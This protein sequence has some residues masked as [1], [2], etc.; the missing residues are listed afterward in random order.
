[1]HGLGRE[2]AEFIIAERDR[3]GPYRSPVDFVRRV[4]PDRDALEQLVF[5]GALDTL[6]AR[7]GRQANRR[8]ILW[9]L[10]EWVAAAGAHESAQ[11]GLFAS[12]ELDAGFNRAIATGLEDFD[13]WP[14]AIYEYRA[15]NGITVERHIMAYLRRSLARQGVKRSDQL[16]SLK[17]GSTVTVAGLCLR[18]HRPPTRSGRTVV[19]ACLEDEAGL[20]DVT[21]FEDVYQKYGDAVFT[22]PFVSVQGVLEKRGNGVSVTANRIRELGYVVP[23]GFK[24][25]S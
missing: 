16:S 3:H 19:F 24:C 15:L 18:P 7:A 20:A 1:M 6:A 5:A 10:P 4:H 2:G 14:R 22:K 17:P 12:S 23:S 11:S 25:S 9:R 13:P 21:I 8:Q